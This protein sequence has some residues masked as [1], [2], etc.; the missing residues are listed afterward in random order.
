VLADADA[1]AELRTASAAALGT[2]RDPSA[3]AALVSV[4][5]VAP[6]QV[7]RAVGTALAGTRN[8]GEALLA[9]VAAGK[10]SPRLLTDPAVGDK[11][12]AAGV[13][14]LDERLAVL[15]KG[16]PDADAATTALVDAR[17]RAFAA[18]RAAASADRGRA[19][20][21]KNCAACHAVGGEG[22][23]VG[24]QLDGAGK[25]GADRLAEDILDPNRNVDGA[26]RYSVLTLD[27]GDVVTGLQRRVEGGATVL[28]D[29]QGKEFS[30]QTARI[31]K[32]TESQLS[33]MPAN[34]GDLIPE[35]EFN[36]LMAFLLSK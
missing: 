30:V 18:G 9:A 22:G 36:D 2:V 32:R 17:R 27:D 28:A 33:L 34:F 29:A 10:A 24:P 4:V 26:F 1:P 16:M 25:R 11:L 12:R 3:A 5:A 7:Q 31:G 19:V 21:V 14:R 8:G 15:T 20:F 35:Q 6:Q 13:D 23:L